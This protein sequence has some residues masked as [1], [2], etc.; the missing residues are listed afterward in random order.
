VSDGPPTRI[1]YRPLIFLIAGEPSGDLL[2]ARLMAALAEQGKCQFAGV[3]GPRMAEEGLQNL[4]PMAELSVMGLTEVLPHVPH[5]LRRIRETVTE[6]NRLNPAAI[7]TIDSPGFNFRV[8]NKLKHLDAPLIH[9]VAPT[10]WAW[11]PGRA[12]KI[13]AIYDHLLALLPFEPPYFEAVG[14]PCTFIGH[15]VL[16]SGAARGDAKGM[17]RRHDI[18]PTVPLICLLPGSRQSET[19]RLLPVFADTLR[20]LAATRPNMRVVVAVAGDVAGEVRDAATAW[21][22]HP[23]VITTD[24]DKFDAFAAADA[25]LAASGTVALELAMAGTPT[26]V[27]YKVNPLSAW[28]ARRIIRTPFVNLTNIV[29][30]REAVPELL[31]EDCRP[32]KLADAVE[33][34]L[35]DEHARRA[36]QEASKE[37]LALLAGNDQETPS[38]RAAQ[39]IFDLIANRPETA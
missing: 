11:R 28:I 26:V 25:A 19:S 1:D 22:G 15:S 29:L 9:Y 4:F 37:A 27:T 3:G 36:Q 5:L 16:E 2:G 39:V 24:D 20:L 10:V 6:A 13:A 38:H 32:D 18:D 30:N 21:P 8:A 35:D 33:R 14:L 31:Q 7:V 23:I 12:Q 17:R 34:L